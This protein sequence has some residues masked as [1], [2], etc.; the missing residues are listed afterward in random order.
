MVGLLAD[1]FGGKIRVLV[2]AMIAGILLCYLLGTAWFMYITGT[3]LAKSLLLCVVPFLPGDAL[4]I[5]V[6]ALLASRL[7][8]IRAKR[9]VQAV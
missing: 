8:E 1:R 7:R 4:K 2:P 5:A 6:G 3:D 9:A